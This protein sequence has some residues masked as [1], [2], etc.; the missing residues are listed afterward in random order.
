MTNVAEAAAVGAAVAVVEETLFRG[1]LQRELSE[2]MPGQ[3]Q[4][5][6]YG[7]WGAGWAASWAVGL[8]FAAVHWDM[9]AFP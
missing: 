2:S 8:V 9:P 5:D 1:W 4:K 7:G 6:A 3:D